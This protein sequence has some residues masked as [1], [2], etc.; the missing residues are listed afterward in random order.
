M[1]A[2]AG[3]VSAYGRFHSGTRISRQWFPASFG[4]LQPLLQ[5]VL[6]GICRCLSFFA[7]YAFLPRI[8][9]AVKDGLSLQMLFRWVS[10]AV[11]DRFALHYFLF[12]L[13][14][15]FFFHLQRLSLGCRLGRGR[16][17]G[18]YCWWRRGNGLRLY[19]RF[20]SGLT[21]TLH[22]LVCYGVCL[23]FKMIIRLPDIKLAL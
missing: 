6:C 17:Y 13:T 3:E 2:H 14:F 7:L 22:H 15:C 4:A 5:A 16:W 1:D 19:C 20:C 12:L 23:F 18:G 21:E 11:E 10:H 8:S 9:H